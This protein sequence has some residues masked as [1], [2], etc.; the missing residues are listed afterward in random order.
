MPETVSDLPV[1]PPVRSVLFVCAQNVCRSVAAEA[2]FRYLTEN[3]GL[4]V[5]ADSAGTYA[6]LGRPPDPALCAAARLRGYD[7][8]GLRSRPFTADDRK[9]FDLIL[10]ADRDGLQFVRT[11]AGAGRTGLLTDYSSAFDAEEVTF[12]EGAR[13][14][15]RML[16]QVED[17]CLGLFKDL[18]ARPDRKPAQ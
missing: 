16:D 6:A 17:A 8:S 9:R 11:T 13:G 15:D 18:S 2:V 10:A 4:E 3:A 5:E 14:Y 1:S 12:P 7:L